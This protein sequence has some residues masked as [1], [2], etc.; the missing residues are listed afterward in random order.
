MTLLILDLALIYVSLGVAIAYTIRSYNPMEYDLNALELAVEI[1]DSYLD[2][3]SQNESEQ[4]IKRYV[5]FCLF[6]VQLFTAL[7]WPALLAIGLGKLI[8][9]S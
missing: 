9:R 8:R 7:S 3:Y 5:K 4:D 2:R 6:Q 1:V